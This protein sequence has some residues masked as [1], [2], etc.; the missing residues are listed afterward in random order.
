MKKKLFGLTLVVAMVLGLNVVA[1]GAD[2]GG[3]PPIKIS[4]PICI[5]CDC[6]DLC[7]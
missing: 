5:F 1:L 4:I 7:D 2:G 6:Q 3:V